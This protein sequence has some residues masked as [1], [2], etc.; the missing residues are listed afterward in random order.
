MREGVGE[1][2]EG[3]MR[4][5]GRENER[6]IVCVQERERR[7]GRMREG[8]RESVEGRMRE[9]VRKRERGEGG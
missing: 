1:G 7:G 4:E 3:R 6:E 2:G 8:V 5:S 9:S